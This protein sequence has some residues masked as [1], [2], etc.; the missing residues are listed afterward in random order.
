MTLTS[1]GRYLSCPRGGERHEYICVSQCLFPHIEIFL[2]F[3]T[4]FLFDFFFFLWSHYYFFIFKGHWYTASNINLPL[5]SC[6]VL[7]NPLGQF[8][9]NKVSFSCFTWGLSSLL[10]PGKKHLSLKQAHVQEPRQTEF[11][12]KEK[13]Q[14][15]PYTTKPTEPKSIPIWIPFKHLDGLYSLEKI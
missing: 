2:Y 9:F 13:T 10:Q 6:G 12:Q 5:L 4:G 3:D 7:E 15:V 14:I 11:N 1:P 8:I